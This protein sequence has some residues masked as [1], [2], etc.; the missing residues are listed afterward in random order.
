MTEN[1]VSKQLSSKSQLFYLEETNMSS[2]FINKVIINRR[3]N[4]YVLL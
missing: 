2:L 4:K 3:I 1:F